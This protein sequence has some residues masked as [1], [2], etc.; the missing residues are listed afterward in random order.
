MSQLEIA[1]GTDLTSAAKCLMN[2]L[3]ADVFQIF[4]GKLLTLADAS[5]TDPQQRK[6]FKDITKE[7]IHNFHFNTLDNVQKQVLNNIGIVIG[8]DPPL[9]AEP[10]SPLPLKVIFKYTREEI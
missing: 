5:F 6:A 1:D 4:T 7:M 3:T 8:D 9:N 2:N 10:L